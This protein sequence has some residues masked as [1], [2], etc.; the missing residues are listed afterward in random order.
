MFQHPYE[1]MLIQASNTRAWAQPCPL[2]LKYVLVS[3]EFSFT[4]DVFP[5]CHR[6]VLRAGFSIAPFPDHL[7][8]LR[9]NHSRSGRSPTT[10][11]QRTAAVTGM[12]EFST[13]AKL[14]A[15]AVA[16]AAGSDLRVRGK[17]PFAAICALFSIFFTGT[18]GN[19]QRHRWTAL[20]WTIVDCA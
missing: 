4:P 13:V 16:L 7:P 8:V 11:A 10:Q 15:P 12:V 6:A 9:E 17:M 20:F 3:A 1:P 19:W 14:P 2:L 18:G 5:Q